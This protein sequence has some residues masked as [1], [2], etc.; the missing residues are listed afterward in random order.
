MYTRGPW[1]LE[2][3][4]SITSVCHPT[5]P[6]ETICTGGRIDNRRVIALAPEM[7]ELLE[8]IVE[9]RDDSCTDEIEQIVNRAHGL[10]S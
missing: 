7:L 2:S 4:G 8:G 1:K 10:A 3:D 9:R 6:V 5:I